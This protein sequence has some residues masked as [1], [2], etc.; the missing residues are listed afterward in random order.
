[1]PRLEELLERARKLKERIEHLSTLEE[2]LSLAE[3][4][5]SNNVDFQESVRLLKVDIRHNTKMLKIKLSEIKD[6]KMKPSENSP[7]TSDQKLIISEFCMDNNCNSVRGFYPSGFIFEHIV[8]LDGVDSRFVFEW[9]LALHIDFGGSAHGHVETPH[10]QAVKSLKGMDGCTEA[11][12]ILNDEVLFTKHKLKYTDRSN[13]VFLDF[14]EVYPC[15]E[16]NSLDS[17][18]QKIHPKIAAFS[19]KWATSYVYKKAGKKVPVEQED[20]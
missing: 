16:Y 13:A 3:E 17:A 4:Q 5:N 12:V 11:N 7:L 9:D 1:M 20:D 19:K 15:L 8:T 2:L 18:I 6:T 14:D 10:L